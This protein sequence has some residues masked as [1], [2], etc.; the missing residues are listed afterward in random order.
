MSLE[1]FSK[2]DLILLV[3][4]LISEVGKLRAQVDSLT[5]KISILQEE[6]Q[7]LSVKKSSTNSSIPPSS[8]LQRTNQSLRNKSNLKKGGQPGHKGHTLEMSSKPD[9][10]VTHTPSFCST[11]GNTLE[12][13]I[14]YVFER[15]QVVDIPPILPVFTEHQSFAKTC[16][17]G[18]LN[19]GTFPHN[20]NAPIQ[21]GDSIEALAVY[22]SSRQYMPFSR[23]SECFSDVFGINICQS[24][25]VNALSRFASKAL[26]VYQRIKENIK[27]APVL[28]TDETGVKVNGKKGWFWVWQNELN[29]YISFSL[30]R[31]FDT[32]NNLFPNGFK[33]STLVSDCWAAQLK[34]DS[35]KHQICLA[36]LQRELNYFI[37]TNNEK[38]AIDMKSILK[39]ALELKKQIQS[40]EKPMP[41]RQ[42]LEKRLAT[43]LEISELS[44][45]K[46]LKAFQKRLQKHKY[47][48]F[49]F[50]YDS[51]IPPDN[52]AS[53]RAI[54]N[55]KVKSKISG[56]FVSE[57]KATDYAI[58]RSIIDTILK[59]GANVIDSLRLI[60]QFRP[61]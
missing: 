60:A 35:N 57:Q 1:N 25:I 24:S 7:I 56:Q 37:E 5:T 41:Q 4:S 40:Y 10:I 12:N 2:K 6:K 9:N 14:G 16:K 23:L 53:E 32:I 26:P 29:T 30:S 47:K 36:H 15:R 28:G 61:E 42:K 13:E 45:N 27:K 31:G 38:W 18:C 59:N 44:K 34:C 48:I 8:D 52:N 17:C 39:D 50:L 11:C 51:R 58:L 54:R 43:I 33:K 20:I 55:V 22:F 49:P 3:E 19:K 46:K 21:Y